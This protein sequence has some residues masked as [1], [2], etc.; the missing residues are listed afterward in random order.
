MHS[1]KPIGTSSK[2]EKVPSSTA[3]WAALLISRSITSDFVVVLDV[4]FVVV[5]DVSDVEELLLSLLLLL[6]QE[7]NDTTKTK[8][9]KIFKSFINFS[10]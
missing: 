2:F 3:A 8:G 1:N 6:P 7:S 5:L 4:S 9:A 10:K